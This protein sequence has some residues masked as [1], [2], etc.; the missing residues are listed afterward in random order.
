MGIVRAVANDQCFTS[1]INLYHLFYLQNIREVLIDTKCR[2]YVNSVFLAISELRVDFNINEPVVPDYLR[3]KDLSF[4]NLPEILQHSKLK[5]KYDLLV[6]HRNNFDAFVP[7]MHRAAF[8]YV[9]EGKHSDPSFLPY[10]KMNDCFEGVLYIN[11]FHSIIFPYTTL[12]LYQQ[13][14]V[15]DKPYRFLRK[16]QQLLRATNCKTIVEIGSCRNTVSH[17]LSVVD[18]QCCNDS[19]STLFWCELKKCKVYTVDVNPACEKILIDAYKSGKFN[20]V[21]KLDINVEDGLTFL[22][23]YNGRPI[24]FLFLDAWDVV[25]NID[26]AEKHLE[27]YNFAKQ[28]LSS[29]V[30]FLAIDDTD[31]ANGGKGRL[32]IPKLIHDGW[33]MLYRGRHAVFYRGALKH[34]F[35]DV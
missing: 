21:C 11:D 20:M 15:R 5:F 22:K 29:D 10:T 6:V 23:Q 30:C 26:Y 34:L 7:I 17:D 14:Y 25:D 8:I 16:M 33:I 32:L 19:H 27:A 12:S 9:Y 2:K 24:H 1:V 4:L 35:A 28:Y 31:I 3:S 18:P 13:T